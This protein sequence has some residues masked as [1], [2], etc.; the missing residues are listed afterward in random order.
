MPSFWEISAADAD[1][2][3]RAVA[4]A[5]ASRK[6]AHAFFL[7]ILVILS[8]SFFIPIPQANS[9][10]PQAFPRHLAPVCILFFEE[11]TPLLGAKQPEPGRVTTRIPPQFFA[12]TAAIPEYRVTLH[13]RDAIKLKR[14]LTAFYA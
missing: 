4:P 7:A 6:T 2:P 1:G 3:L 14:I 13:A 11:V 8:P 12:C 9:H 5:S 10:C